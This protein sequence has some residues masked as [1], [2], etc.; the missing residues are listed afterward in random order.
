METQQS[1]RF[2]YVFPDFVDRLNET[3]LSTAAQGAWIRVL[4]EQ[5]RYGHTY[6]AF[7]PRSDFSS[8]L[9]RTF[10]AHGLLERH[11]DGHLHIVDWEGWNGRKEY[12]RLLNRERQQR[13]RDRQKE[14]RNGDS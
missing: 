3:G 5:L 8:R 12:K 1:E 6:S 4:I 14:G 7:H 11:E 13:W 10:V 9:V 2:L